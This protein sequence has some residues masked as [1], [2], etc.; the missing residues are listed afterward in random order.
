MT[1]ARQR[2]WGR[3]DSEPMKTTPFLFLTLVLCLFS[4][5][6]STVPILDKQEMLDRQTW[7]DNKDWDWY[8]EKIPFF[9]SP[10]PDID[11]T[12]YYRWEVMTKHLTYG[13]P[14]TGYTFT[15]FIDRPFWSGAYGSISCPLGHQFYEVRWLKDRLVIEDFARYWFETPGATSTRFAYR[16]S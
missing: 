13:S 2:G 12:Y 7:W 15:E 6:R 9:E 16:R 11:A 14:Q 10:D 4:C 8:K 5:A 3:L 1:V